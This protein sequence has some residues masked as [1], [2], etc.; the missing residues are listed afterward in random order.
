MGTTHAGGKSP[1]MSIGWMGRRSLAIKLFWVTTLVA[2]AVMVT[3]SIVG[4]VQSRQQAVEAVQREMA[5]SLQS[6]EQSLSMLFSSA[7]R[8]GTDILPVLKRELGGAPQ[9]DGTMVELDDGTQIPLLVVG[10]H[11]LNGDVDLLNRVRENTGADAAVLVR[12]DDQWLR[13]ATL[14]QDNEGRFLTGSAVNKHDILARSLD[15]G[16]PYTGIVQRNGRWYT[17]SIEPLYDDAGQVFGG[18]SVR[19][20]IDVQVQQLLMWVRSVNVAEF[21]RLGILQKTGDGKLVPLA[22]AQAGDVPGEAVAKLPELISQPR[23]VAEVSL[24]NGSEPVDQFI[25]WESVDGWDWVVYGVGEKSEFLQASMRQLTQQ[26][27]L[28]LA[29][30]LL[31]SLL[32]GWLAARTLRPV[33]QVMDVMDKLGQGDLTARVPDVPS[34][35]RNEV[36]VL[37]GNA[38]RTQQSLARTIAAV[39][40]SVEEISIGASEI[41]A[42]NTDLSSRT[43]EQAASLQETAAS[44]EQLAATVKQN[45]DHARQAN[46]LAVDASD[47][48]HRGEEVVSRVVDTMHRISDSSGKIGEIVGVIDSIAFQTNILALNAAVE[49]ARAGEQ[50]RGF[51]VVASEVRSLAQRSAEAAK[52]IKN[53]IESSIAEVTNGAKQVEGAGSTMQELLASVGRVTEIIKEISAAS[54]EQ[55]TGIDQIN[56]AVSQMDEVTQQ[57]AALVEQAAAAAGSLQDQATRLTEAV[58]VF[59]LAPGSGV[60]VEM[61]AEASYL[62]SAAA[63]RGAGVGEDEDDERPPAGLR[64]G[65]VPSA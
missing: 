50:G 3:I 65:A 46:T 10:D 22:D 16:N 56:L 36:H 38:K 43:E 1:A 29:G 57:N 51:A 32:V 37:L 6:V 40:A 19:V 12:K 28:M 5:A 45:S 17:M 30:T 31:I 13:A 61:Q 35:S 26:A 44:M 34:H 27:A 60:V 39:R 15:A 25:A 9:R 63:A 23:G 8:Q 11:I 47:V 7:S 64:L 62:S 52:E 33:R 21:G 53:L 54:D 59:R 20:P 2:V 41:A 4:A 14:L 49:A 42:G 18:L 24:S 58:A 55:S 48:A